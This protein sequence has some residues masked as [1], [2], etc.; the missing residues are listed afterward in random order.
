MRFVQK[1][2]PIVASV[3]LLPAL[4]WASKDA[5]AP[6]TQSAPQASAQ[7][8]QASAGASSRKPTAAERNLESVLAGTGLKKIAMTPGAMKDALQDHK[9]VIVREQSTGKAFQVTDV[10]KKHVTVRAGLLG[11]PQKLKIKQFKRAFD[12]AASSRGSR[13]SFPG[14]A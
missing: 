1:V 14:G 4:A 6:R 2:L 11:D 7:R 10:S 5:P 13:G 3:L 9:V 8:A 12:D